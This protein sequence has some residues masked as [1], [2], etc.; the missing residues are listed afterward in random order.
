MPQVVSAVR[1]HRPSE[2]HPERGA[3]GD[4]GLLC[5]IGG[6]E[7]VHQLVA[8][9]YHA[10]GK[11]LSPDDTAEHNKQIGR[12]AQ[13]LAHALT[14]Q[15]EPV[16]S[17]RASFLARG[18]NQALFEA[19]LEYFEA[20]LMELGF[21]ASFSGQLVRTASDLYDQSATPLSIAC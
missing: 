16:R 11:Y 19:L 12:Q 14:E 4:C 13:F 1:T 7:F 3:A 8:E 10:I 18:L 5:V 21:T 2:T 6:R 20:R 15:A 17:D 9:F